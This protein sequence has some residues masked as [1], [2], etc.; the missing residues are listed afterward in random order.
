MM[1]GQ[2]LVECPRES[3]TFP[4]RPH[5]FVS[6]AKKTRDNGWESAPV[7]CFP[8]QILSAVGVRKRLPNLRCFD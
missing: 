2:P 1:F 3:E 4:V 8:L 7:S 6:A 5:P